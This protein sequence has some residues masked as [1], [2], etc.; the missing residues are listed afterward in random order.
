MNRACSRR[1]FAKTAAVGA[2]GLLAAQASRASA[3][4]RG[5]SDGLNANVW[6]AALDELRIGEAVEF[7]Y[8]P[9]HPALAVRVDGQALGGVGPGEDVVAFHR[10][11]PHMGCPLP[12]K[13]L[14]RLAKGELGPCF[15]HR[16]LFDIRQGGRQIVGRASQDCVQVRLAVVD[17]DLYAVGHE[18]LP[19]GD[20]LTESAT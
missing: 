4:D 10:A 9:G 11:C 18:G 13:D 19:F 8:P 7:E 2:A 14:I 5:A 6:I 15:C 17:G 12:I 3:A 16:S 1:S 20:P